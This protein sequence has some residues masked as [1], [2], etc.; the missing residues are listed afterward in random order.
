MQNCVLHRGASKEPKDIKIRLKQELLDKNKDL[1]KSESQNLND[2]HELVR[3]S[4]T[5]ETV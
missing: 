4:L 1:A 2:V 5:D 3:T